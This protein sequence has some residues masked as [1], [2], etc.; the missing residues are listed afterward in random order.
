MK[1]RTL[2]ALAT[3]VLALASSAARAEQ[4]GDADLSFNLPPKD[5]SELA[6]TGEL[7]VVGTPVDAELLYIDMNVTIPPFDNP[8]VRQ[9]IAYAIPY[10]DI[11]GTAL[12]GS[13]A[14]PDEDEEA[15]QESSS[16]AA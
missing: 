3:L 11:L 14:E 10:E 2:S 15:A 16:Q 9:A 13:L 6:K 4:K 5:F 12:Y 8:K 1:P 7:T